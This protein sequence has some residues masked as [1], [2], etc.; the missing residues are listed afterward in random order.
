VTS[1]LDV[2]DTISNLD[3]GANDKPRDEVR[4]ESVRLG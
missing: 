4:I 1:G 3:T 2:A